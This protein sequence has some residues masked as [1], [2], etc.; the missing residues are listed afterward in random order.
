MRGLRLRDAHREGFLRER[1]YRVMRS[2][3]QEMSDNIEG[4][5]ETILAALERR[6]TL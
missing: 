2:V 5:V 1:G 4:V 3:N 6:T